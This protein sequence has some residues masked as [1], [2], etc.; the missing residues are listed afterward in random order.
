MKKIIISGMAALTAVLASSSA[1]S[2][3]GGIG[4]QVSPFKEH[5]DF[6][7]VVYQ[8]G[9]F[10]TFVD[11]RSY[12]DSFG[13]NGWV[14]VG[15]Y[16]YSSTQST[17]FIS[18]AGPAFANAVSVNKNSGDTSIN[19]TLDPSD[20]TNCSSYNVF[21]SVTVDL[22]GQNDGWKI[23]NQGTGKST[24]NGTNYK[25]NFQAEDFSESFTGT[26]GFYTGT[27]GGTA[28]SI[29]HTSLTKVE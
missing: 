26:N 24:D 25:Y 16:D 11:A 9:E 17:G 19:A 5:S 28:S 7:Y 14:T 8:D 2:A 29:H 23:S 4:M 3:P 12:D 10:V 20:T 6:V 22:A 18:C 27:F 15:A 21:A 13:P 1:Y